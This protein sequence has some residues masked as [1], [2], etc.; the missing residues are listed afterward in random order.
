[1]TAATVHEVFPTSDTQV[2]AHQ[3]RMLQ[4][5]SL[6]EVRHCQRVM[7]IMMSQLHPLRDHIMRV[8]AS[9]EAWAQA[10]AQALVRTQQLT[11]AQ[12]T[13]DTSWPPVDNFKVYFGDRRREMFEVDDD[14]S[15]KT[16]TET[17]PDTPTSPPPPYCGPN[18]FSTAY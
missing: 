3:Q 8:F 17:E 16:E 2:P 4:H 12:M 15:S 14:F 1:M 6:F 11:V 5:P 7:E 18:Q 13:L 10:D 9:K